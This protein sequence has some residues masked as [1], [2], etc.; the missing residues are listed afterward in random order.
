MESI[1]KIGEAATNMLGVGE[2]STS[3]STNFGVPNSMAH[4]GTLTKAT[5]C[6]IGHVKDSMTA[7][8]YGPV[9]VSDVGLLEKVLQFN[10]EKIP[11]RN[12]HALGIGCYGTFTVTNDITK[13]TKAKVFSQVGKKT[14]LFARFSGIFTEQGDPETVRDPR[15]FAIKFYTEEGN[16]DLLG[17]NTPVFAV[18]DAKPG[19]DQVHAFKRNPRNGCWNPTQTFDFVANHPEGLHQFAMMYSDRSGTPASFRTMNAYGCHTFSLINENNERFWVKFHIISLQGAQGFNLQQAKAVA[20]EDPNFLSRDLLTAIDQGNFPRWRLSIQIMPE[21]EGY[22]HP[23]TFDATKVWKHRDYPLI[24]VGIIEMNR[25]I[26][27]YFTETEQVAFSPATFVP[28]IGLSPDKLLQGRLLIY[29]DTQHHRIGPNYKQ[30]YINRPHAMEPNHNYVGG[31]MH[32]EIKDKFPHYSGSVFGGLAPNPK[33]IEP[34]LKCTGDAGYYNY[35]NEGTDE[36]YYGQVRD[37]WNVLNDEQKNNMCENFAADLEKVTEEKIV[38][39]MLNHF[40]KCDPMWAQMVEIKIRDRKQGKKTNNENLTVKWCLE[41]VYSPNLNKKVSSDGSGTQND[42]T[43]SLVDSICDLGGRLVAVDKSEMK[44]HA[45]SWE[46]S[47]SLPEIITTNNKTDN[48][49][50]FIGFEK[51]GNT[52]NDNSTKK[53]SPPGPRGSVIIGNENCDL[54]LKGKAISGLNNDNHPVK[55]GIPRCFGTDLVRENICRDFTCNALWYDPINKC[56]IDPTG[57][58]QGIKDVLEKVIRIPVKEKY[59]NFWAKGNPSKIMRYY[60][61]MQMGYK[62]AN[63]KQDNL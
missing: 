2:T 14:E 34:P 52:T 3:M 59:W 1:K 4:T 19:P 62:P 11:A 48:D 17:I 30:L 7:G 43:S 57:D 38:T 21:A 33:Y 40:A 49:Y 29:D 45:K 5:G 58:G 12:V 10:R 16:W 51:S 36:D 23:W 6:P 24:E 63:R 41:A 39:M 42:N 61:F 53:P 60:K 13:Y 44:P 22:T 55:S 18:R 37:F 26:T 50:C 54:R 20:G 56:I 32:I 28:G 8:A 35:P 15:G 9:V 46:K 27:D 25:N 47:A 31:N